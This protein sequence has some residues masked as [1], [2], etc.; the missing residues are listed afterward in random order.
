[1]EKYE[2]ALLL[3]GMILV[4]VIFGWVTLAVSFVTLL[5]GLIYG[6]A[7]GAEN[8]SY[9]WATAQDMREK[10]AKKQIHDQVKA[11]QTKSHSSDSK[12]EGKDIESACSELEDMQRK[13]IEDSKSVSDPL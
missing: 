4:F 2:I 13:K 3:T 10:L 8:R 12:P 1:M 11:F 9:V 7:L 5:T 6:V